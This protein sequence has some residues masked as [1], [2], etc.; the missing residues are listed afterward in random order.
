MRNELDR[1]I[2]SIPD[3]KAVWLI[4]DP[5]PDQTFLIPNNLPHKL[6]LATVIRGAQRLAGIM[7]H[8]MKYGLGNF[9]S[10]LQKCASHRLTM[11]SG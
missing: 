8:E 10:I 11:S 5:P 7:G 1:F 2:V 9:R 3:A 4:D 6:E